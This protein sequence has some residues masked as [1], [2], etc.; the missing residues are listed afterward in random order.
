MKLEKVCSSKRFARKIES[1]GEGL[2]LF[3][4]Y[5]I[6]KK[7]G[8]N[9]HLLYEDKRKPPLDIAINPNDGTIEYISYFAQDEM[10]SNISDI[11]Q[12]IN[13]KMQISICDDRFNEDNA[14]IIEECKF[15][16]IKSQKNIWIIREDIEKDTLRAYKVNDTNNILFK[17][18]DFAG[19]LLKNIENEEI[20]AIYNSK[21]LL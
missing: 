6:D 3:E 20:Q 11:P 5:A 1:M 10:I 21:C 15:K 16:I 13:E 12:I 17:E 2:V 18:S 8:Q 14:N 19:I 9:Y 7:V 4:I